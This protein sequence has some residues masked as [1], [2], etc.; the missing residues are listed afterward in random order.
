MTSTRTILVVG[1]GGKGPPSDGTPLPQEVK[2]TVTTPDGLKQALNTMVQ[3]AAEKGFDV[4]VLQL[5]DVDD[6]CAWLKTVSGTLASRSWDG[7]IIGNGIR[8]TPSLTIL[9]E[10]LIKIGR[11][12]APKTP[13]GFNTHPLDVLDTIQRMF[14][15]S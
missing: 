8:G 1:G 5:D 4:R 12:I 2:A 13:M 11:E 15:L 10:Q 7:F 14:A 3:Q 6:G 9:F